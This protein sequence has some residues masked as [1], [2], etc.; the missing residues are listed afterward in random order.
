MSRILAPHRSFCSSGSWEAA[1]IQSGLE[2]TLLSDLIGASLISLMARVE[3]L[4]DKI[5][6]HAINHH[7]AV[8]KEGVWR[9]GDFF[10][11]KVSTLPAR[12]PLSCRCGLAPQRS[13]GVCGMCKGGLGL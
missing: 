11:L 1:G 13:R 12:E 2:P 4:E 8:P 5:D 9:G 7:P 10:D 6:D 3:E